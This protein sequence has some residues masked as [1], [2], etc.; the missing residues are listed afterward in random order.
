MASRWARAFKVRLA[1]HS[2]V[3]NKITTVVTYIAFLYL[4]LNKN[5]VS[6]NAVRSFEIDQ[7]LKCT[8]ITAD[9]VICILL[10]RE[11]PITECR[12]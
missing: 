8:E 1:A 2:Q 5:R 4:N 3:V 10:A 9:I 11:A 6:F 12:Y 7:T